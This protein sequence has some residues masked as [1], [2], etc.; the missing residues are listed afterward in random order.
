MMRGGGGWAS[1]PGLV[2]NGV[3][4]QL[5]SPL[6]EW[7]HGWLRPRRPAERRERQK[8]LGKDMAC[9]SGCPSQDAGSS[10]CSSLCS[11]WS[12]CVQQTPPGRYSL[13]SSD[14]NG[15]EANNA[16]LATGLLICGDKL[17]KAGY[18]KGYFSCTRQ[19]GSDTS[20]HVPSVPGVCPSICQLPAKSSGRFTHWPEFHI[21]CLD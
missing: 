1:L 19:F 17:K 9:C 10:I 14:G 2:P 5:S 18:D 16:S 8:W 6:S 4:P 12:G 21:S 11:A 13:L 15:F 20:G 3:K 7:L